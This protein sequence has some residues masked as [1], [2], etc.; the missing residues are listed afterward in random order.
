MHGRNTQSGFDA[1]RV[2]VT[3]IGRGV[4]VAEEFVVR[5][6]RPTEPDWKG[7]Y[8]R[9]IALALLSTTL[10]GGMAAAADLG[11]RGPAYKAA[12]PPAPYFSWTGCFIG[13]HVGGL[14]ATKDWTD[15]TTPGGAT[16]G[17]SLGSHD[18]DGG[19]GG[20]QA[21]CDYQFAGGFVVGIQGD[22][23]W[24]D[25]DGSHADQ[26][27]TG[28]TDRTRIKSLSSV[29]GRVGYAWDRFLG[30]VRGGGA[31]ERDNYDVFVTS[32]NLT[33]ATAS[34]TRGGWT[35]GVGGEYAFT[36]WL[37]GFAEYN[38]YDFGTRENR[39]ITPAG[40]A[41]G[42]ADIKETKSVA[43]VGLNFRFGS[44][45]PLYAKY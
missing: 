27:L 41:F 2:T 35:L 11:V 21:G 14:W 6:V 16:F 9:R 32:T 20:I 10:L 40:G 33:L 19:L 5:K 37:S 30:Y 36:P 12:P 15:R 42:I 44:G 28:V 1:Q 7:D 4:Y 8:M 22:Y 23:A 45:G 39:F 25:T 24:T 13:G 17:R 26:L 34:E 43:K 38:Y 29:T 3:G 18:A 31:W